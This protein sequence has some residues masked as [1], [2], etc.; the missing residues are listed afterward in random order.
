MNKNLFTYKKSGVNISAADKFVSFISNISSKKRG[1]KKNA[2]IGGFGSVS[3]L[4]KGI[5]N[6]KIVACTDGVGTKIEVANLLNKYDTIGIDLVAMSVNDLIVQGAKPL[7]FLDYISI[8]KIDLKKMKSIIRGI[9]KGCDISQCSLVGGE[10][11]EMPDTYEKGKFDLAGFAIGITNKKKILN[12]NK[13]KK[14]DLILAVPSSGLHSNGFSLVRR[15]LKVK[16]IDIKK[17]SFL[18]KEL[19]RPTKIYVKEILNLVRKNLLNGCA[20]IT[21]GGLAD[22]ISRVIPKNLCAEIDLSKIKPLKIFN[23]LKRNKISDREMLKTFNCGVGF[24]LIINPKN[25]NKI[26]KFFSKEYKPY[27]I[28]KISKNLNKVNLNGK[29]NWL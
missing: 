28:G 24:C 11:A 20:N 7:F 5:K 26:N 19:I 13:I 4:P 21:G 25:I 1:N 15:L 12:K 18:K 3:D 27:I 6:P 9:I 23:W 22:N 29:V 2:N 8:N 16:K 14:G 10:T 17:N